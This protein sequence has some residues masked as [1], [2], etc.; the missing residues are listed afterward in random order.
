MKKIPIFEEY[1]SDN[2][3]FLHV[4]YVFKQDKRKWNGSKKV[5]LK[6]EYLLELP[7][8]KLKPIKL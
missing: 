8:V 2:G 3:K 4:V 7:Y 1:Y 5:F 6:K